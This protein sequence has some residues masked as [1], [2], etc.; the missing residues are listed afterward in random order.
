MRA[1]LDSPEL[2]RDPRLHQALVQR[3]SFVARPT[4]ESIA[5]L[6][7]ATHDAK[8]ASERAASAYAL[9]GA[10][11]NAMRAGD[12]TA[13]ARYGTPM[14]DSLTKARSGDEKRAWLGALGNLGWSGA[15]PR[16]VAMSHDADASVRAAS[17][18]A[19]RKTDTQEV[20]AALRDLARDAVPEVAERAFEAMGAQPTL[21]SDDLASIA[22]LVADG[23]TPPRADSALLSLLTAHP[24]GGEPVQTMLRTLLA[25]NDADKPMAAQI[26]HALAAMP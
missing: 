17:A 22:S 16:V 2:E 13:G 9:G 4:S 14:V 8:S 3:F 21:G 25:R 19:L 12:E 26:R 20:R 1:A 6:E 10:A 5:F 15:V 7:R 18:W 23:S 24:E 11:G